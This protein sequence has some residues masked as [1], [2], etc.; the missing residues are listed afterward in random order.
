MDLLKFQTLAEKAAQMQSEGLSDPNLMDGQE[1]RDF[2][3]PDVQS[4]LGDAYQYSRDLYEDD[5]KFC[6]CLG[7]IAGFIHRQVTGGE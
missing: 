3:S 7:H 4:I 2:D 5:D 6:L 1:R